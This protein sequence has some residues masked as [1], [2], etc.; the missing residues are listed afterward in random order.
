M[1]ALVTTKFGPPDVLR[2]SERP[3]LAPQAGQ[4]HIAV[5]R[6]GLNFSD[7]AARVGLYPDAPKPPMVMGYEVSGVIAELGSGVTQFAVGDRV[8]ALTK[9]GGQASEVTVDAAQVLKIDDAMSFDDA[10]AIPVNYLTAFH[11]LFHVAP[12]KPNMRVLI[13]MA[14]GGVGLAAIQLCK[15][16]SGT[17]I[18]A[19][20]STSKHAFLKS[21][22]VQ[23]CIDSRR[24]NYVEEVRRQ[25]SGQGVHRVLDAL[26]GADWSQGYN[27][28][29]PS[30]HL[31]CFGWANMV[32]GPRRNVFRV[33]REFLSLR[34][35]SPL[36]LMDKNRSVSGINLGHLWN[37]NALLQGHLT[38]L[39]ELYRQQQI[40]PHVD[41]VFPLSSGAAAHQHVHERKN[42]GKVLFDCER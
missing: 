9:F 24:Q 2:F 3:R 27:L 22:G 4:V 37:E 19:C 13:H 7:L 11:M 42:V 26:G 33:A 25:T 1:K 31:L 17:E 34:R 16:V 35:Y 20:A 29:A 32:G 8:L 15:T 23:H 36:D 38:A 21:L 6:A 28:L 18:F 12:L 41:Q 30:G 40:R 14:A 10:A 5:K 39:L